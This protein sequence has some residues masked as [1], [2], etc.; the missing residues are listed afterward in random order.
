MPP[1]RTIEVVFPDGRLIRRRPE[2]NPELFSGD[3][4]TKLAN[5]LLAAWTGDTAFVLERLDASDVSGKV[6][7]SARYDA[8]GSIW[9]LFWRRDGCAILIARFQV[10]GRH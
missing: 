7:G 3:G 9:P 10:S 2:N 5:K 1:Y 8:R 6:H 4:L